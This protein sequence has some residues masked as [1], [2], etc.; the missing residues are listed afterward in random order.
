MLRKAVALLVLA[1]L[2]AVAQFP[3]GRHAYTGPQYWVGLSYGFVDATTIY[4]GNTGTRVATSATRRRSARRS[5]RRLQRGIT[6]G[7]SAGYATQPLTYTT[8][9]VQRRLR[10]VVQRERGRDA[11]HGVHPAAAAARGFHC[12]LQRRR[13]RDAVLELP[14][15]GDRHE[16]AAG[17]TAATTSRSASAAASAT[18]CRR[19]RDLYVDRRSW[20]SCCIRRASTRRRARRG[21]R[22]FRAAFR[23]GLLARQGF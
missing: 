23:I 5:R 1:A 9:D 15:E 16:A 18:V 8:L 11:V 17:R 12:R 19:R 21:C 14:R 20:T 6:V 2:P 22:A 13:R 3:R 10:H 4:D 7:V